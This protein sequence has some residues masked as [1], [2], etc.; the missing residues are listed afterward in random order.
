MIPGV[1]RQFWWTLAIATTVVGVM[2][3]VGFLGTRM[4]RQDW[5]ELAL[6]R[7][8]LASLER[9]RSSLAR[10]AELFEK[11]KPE[12]TVLE[13]SFADPTAPLP[14]IETIEELGRRFGV[15]VELAI[16]SGESRAAAKNYLLS[17]E[18][19]FGGVMS[20]LKNLEFLPFHTDVVTVELRGIPRGTE[21]D[22]GLVLRLNV[23]I[24][25]VTPPSGGGETP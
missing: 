24:Q 18:G 7:A 20:F 2:G 16:A 23:A 25:I 17:A 11:L 6:A 1:A 14:F 19:S 22:S 21:Q 4:L 5:Q 10:A 13:A 12:R 3:A 8:E 15:A 9:E